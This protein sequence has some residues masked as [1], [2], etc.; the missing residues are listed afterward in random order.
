MGDMKKSLFQKQ[1][2][3]IWWR[4]IHLSGDGYRRFGYTTRVLYDGFINERIYGDVV[5]S[6]REG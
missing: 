6:E 2:T 1:K 3:L 5:D 4:K